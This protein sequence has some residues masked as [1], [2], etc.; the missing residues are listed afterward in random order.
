MPSPAC[1][2]CQRTMVKRHPSLQPTRDHVVPRS[3][4]GRATVLCCLDCNRIK[5]DLLPLAWSAFMLANPEWWRLSRNDIRRRKRLLIV[6]EDTPPLALP[7][8]IRRSK[9]GEAPMPPVI[10]PPELIWSP[11]SEKATPKDGLSLRPLP[12]AWPPDGGL[13]RDNHQLAASIGAPEMPATDDFLACPLLAVHPSKV[14]EFVEE[15]LHAPLGVVGDQ[16]GMV[17][18]H[19]SLE[20]LVPIPAPLAS[21]T[22]VLETTLDPDNRQD[23]DHG[24]FGP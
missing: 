14:P 5:A 10:V 9:Q 22:G 7:A 20:I 12:R 11:G 13:V 15:G 2:Y 8:P 24:G 23:D 17:D 18:L 6:T 16:S 19:R 21:A 3:Q 4:G 1:P